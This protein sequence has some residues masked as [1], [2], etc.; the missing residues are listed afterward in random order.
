MDFFIME[1]AGVEVP[2]DLEV[3]DLVG[4]VASVAAGG[5]LEVEG[6]REAGNYDRI[7]DLLLYCAKMVN[8]FIIM[9]NPS[10]CREDD[11]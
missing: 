6:H 4:E 1:V 10:L 8:Y 7:G 9:K 11:S 5:V 3:V 2:E